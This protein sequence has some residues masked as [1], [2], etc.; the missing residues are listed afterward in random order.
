MVQ[1]PGHELREHIAVLQ[2]LPIL[3]E[4]GRV[5]DRIVRRQPDEPAIQKIVVQLFH[6]LAFRADAVEDLQQQGAQ[7]LLRRDR[8]TSLAGVEL[9]K[10]AVQIAQNIPDK[11]PDLSQRMVRWH[12]LIGRDVRKQAALI[13]K[14]AAH[15]RLR[16]FEMIK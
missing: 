3:G 8:R 14:P 2:P 6:Q 7:Q 5:P 4:G 11:F 13:R 1:K 12:T 15:N 10:A 16:Q 9:S